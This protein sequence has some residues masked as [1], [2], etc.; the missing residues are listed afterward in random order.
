ME[1]AKSYHYRVEMGSRVIARSAMMETLAPVMAVLPVA[2][3]R[4]AIHANF[5]IIAME[6]PSAITRV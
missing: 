6:L 3:Y 2:I 5:T 1:H 4:Q